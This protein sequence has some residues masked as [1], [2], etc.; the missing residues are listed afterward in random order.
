MSVEHP[1]EIDALVD[2]RRQRDDFW[3]SLKHWRSERTP[4]T[5]SAVSM[6][7]TSLFH[8]RSPVRMFSQ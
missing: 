7:E 1:R 6:D 5:N 4:A 3:S 8:S 2:P